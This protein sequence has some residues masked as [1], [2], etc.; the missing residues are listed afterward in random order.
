M[1][2]IQENSEN[3]STQICTET[4]KVVISLPMFPFKPYPN[5][6]NEPI[7]PGTLN[8]LVRANWMISL[9]LGTNFG[10]LSGRQYSAKFLQAAR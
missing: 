2:G 9:R 6:G 5:I 7:R 4:F 1:H 10:T 8:R 3:H